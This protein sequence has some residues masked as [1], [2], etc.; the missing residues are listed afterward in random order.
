MARGEYY[1]SN[2]Y[3]ASPN[4]YTVANRPYSIRIDKIVIH[5]AQGSWSGTLNW[6]T[7]PNAQASAHYTVS[8]RYGL[9]GQSVLE[10]NIA[11]HAGWWRYNQTSIGIEHEGYISNPGYFTNAMYRSSAKL[12]AYLSR[13]YGIPVD[14]YH[15]IGHNEVPGCSGSG[16]GAGCHT[17]PGGYWN[18]TKYMNLVRYYR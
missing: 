1:P 15:I 2:F 7:N 4:N 3:G 10:K 6:F 9:V 12:S 11:W 13:K 14:R 5:V 18:W 17:D 16:G 8:S